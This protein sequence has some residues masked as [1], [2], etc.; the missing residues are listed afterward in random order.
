M[1]VT[2][3]DI[4]NRAEVSIS[5]ASR[6][7]SNTPVSIHDETRMRIIHAAKELGYQRI[8]KSLQHNKPEKKIGVVLNEVESKYRDPYF[9]EIIYGI[10]RELI[11]QGCI[12]EFTFDM[13]ELI[14]SNLL[15]EI[16]K[17]DLGVICVGPFKE[18]YLSKITQ[19]VPLVLSVGGIPE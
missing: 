12:L 19:Q 3:K 6:V 9:S 16:N 7:L 15:S 5:T 1:K 11:E 4:A 2:L 18:E 10:E 13:E 8:S 17:S 14:Q